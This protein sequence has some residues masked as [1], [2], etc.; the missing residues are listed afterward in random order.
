MDGEG[1]G[2]MPAVLA[3]VE[4]DGKVKSAPVASLKTS[5]ATLGLDFPFGISPNFRSD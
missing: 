2:G 1:K 4:I 5:V 3:A